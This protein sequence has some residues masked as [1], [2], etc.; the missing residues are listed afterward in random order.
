M[1]WRNLPSVSYF[2]HLAKRSSCVS[3]RNGVVA[4]LRN[5][6]DRLLDPFRIARYSTGT[7]N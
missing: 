7:E 4:N 6:E 5:M 2:Q 3:S 1:T